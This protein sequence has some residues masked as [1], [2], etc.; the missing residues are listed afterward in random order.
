MHQRRSPTARMRRRSTVGGLVC[1]LACIWFAALGGCST[2]LTDVAPGEET[3][4]AAS[5]A[6]LASLA[7]VV[8]HNFSPG[9]FKDKIVL[10]GA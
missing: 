6:N 5:P 3:A 9:A 7:D 4:Y 2:I 10:V 1:S 8:Q